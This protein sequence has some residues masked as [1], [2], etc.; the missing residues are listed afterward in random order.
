MSPLVN[1]NKYKICIGVG[2]ILVIAYISVTVFSFQ[3]AR[4]SLLDGLLGWGDKK[5]ENDLYN[6]SVQYPR[7]WAYQESRADPLF[8][9]RIF[10]VLFYSPFDSKNDTV[11]FSISIEN[12]KPANTTLEQYKDQI[13]LNFKH[14][15]PSVKN[16]NISSG[17]ISGYP[18]FRLEYMIWFLDHWE[19][20]I[21]YYSLKNGKILEVS[22][23][24][25]PNLIVKYSEPIKMMIESVKFL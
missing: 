11:T 18:G 1:K 13:V 21:D 24:G 3:T 4:N 12:L 22:A 5:Y 14:S 8:P 25:I 6:V 20:S 19:K 23:F 9:D 10:Q 16:L 7:D 15:T 17:N 2:S